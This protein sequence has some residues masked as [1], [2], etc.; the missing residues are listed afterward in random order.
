MLMKLILAAQ[1]FINIV[2][3]F[4]SSLTILL[5]TQVRAVVHMETSQTRN[6]VYSKYSLNR[7][8]LNRYFAKLVVSLKY[9]FILSKI[10]VIR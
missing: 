6:N 4:L 2:Q 10:P 1:L 3:Y 7:Y 5:C 9:F 8:S